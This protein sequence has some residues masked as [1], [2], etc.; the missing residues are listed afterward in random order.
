M[1]QRLTRERAD[2]AARDARAALDRMEPP[3]T[4][5]ST[6]ALPTAPQNEAVEKLDTARDKLDAAAAQAGGS[7]PTRSGGRWPIRSRRFWNARRPPSRRPTGFTPRS[8]RRRGGKGPF[9]RVIPT[10][11]RARRRSRLRFASSGRTIR[12]AAGL[13]PAAHRLRQRDGRGPRRRSRR[14][15]M[16]PTSRAAFDAEL[17]AMQR[18]QG[19]AADEAGLAPPGATRRGA[20]AGRPQEAAGQEGRHP[21]AE[22]AGEPPADPN[23]GRRAGCGS[24][25]GATQGAALAP[26]GTERTHRAVRQGSPR[27]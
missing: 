10:S 2:E 5:L 16:T 18:P 25:A 23:G 11:S 26:G 7:S 12:P 13:G 19:D 9:G 20:Q 17:E 14:G 24:A 4:T 6:A 1:L 15:A 22:G 3:A 8:R 27:S 21:A